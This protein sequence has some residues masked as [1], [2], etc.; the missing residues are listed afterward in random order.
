MTRHGLFVCRR[1]DPGIIFQVWQ[2]MVTTVNFAEEVELSPF[3]LVKLH[4]VFSLP[5][6]HRIEGN[7][8]YG[9][10]L[11]SCPGAVGITDG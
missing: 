5:L 7:E 3:S 1:A 6:L 9:H 11:H 10:H 4:K 2:S 8:T